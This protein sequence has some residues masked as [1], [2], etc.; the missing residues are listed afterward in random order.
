[1]APAPEAVITMI[2]WHTT[3]ARKLARYKKTG[4]IVPPVRAWESAEDAARMSVSSG[5]RVLVRLRFPAS[6]PRLPGHRGRAFVLNQ[7]VSVRDV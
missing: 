1:M 5:R 3:S 4:F 2:V 6:A 7:R